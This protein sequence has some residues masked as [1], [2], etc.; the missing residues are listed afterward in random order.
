MAFPLIAVPIIGD[1]LKAGMDIIDKMVPD[2]DLA[3]KMKQELVFEE[4]KQ[5][6]RYLQVAAEESKN[7]AEINKV[8]AAGNWYQA[9]WRPS[10]G[11]V[12]VLGFAYNFVVYPI[13]QWY[14]AWKAPV[15]FTMPPLLD[16]M[17]WELTAGMLGLA[18]VRTWEKLGGTKKKGR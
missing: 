14:I 8:E 6:D 12:C 3:A 1:L 15:G 9:G 13:L 18:T 11:Y 5:R 7:Q 2:K 4:M 16:N 10:L 17:L